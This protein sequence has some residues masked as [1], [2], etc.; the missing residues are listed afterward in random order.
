[1]NTNNWLHLKNMLLNYSI[2]KVDSINEVRHSLCLHLKPSPPEECTYLAYHCHRMAVSEAQ[3]LQFHVTFAQ[4][5]P[6]SEEERKVRKNVT[7][8]KNIVHNVPIQYH[9]MIP[10]LSRA[11]VSM[12]WKNT[13][14]L[15]V[16]QAIIA[17]LFQ[18][19]FN[20]ILSR[21]LQVSWRRTFLQHV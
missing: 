7:I 21:I 1:M 14:T 6:I 12:G 11:T 19:K 18:W 15:F 9:S 5:V 20:S 16:T 13:I 8:L 4:Y 10:I 3:T 17:S 2:Q